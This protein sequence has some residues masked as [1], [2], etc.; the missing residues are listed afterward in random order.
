MKL[1][2]TIAPAYR[3]LYLC[4][5][6]VVF[7]VPSLVL[8]QQVDQPVA[9][10]FTRRFQI[11]PSSQGIGAGVGQPRS[12]NSEFGESLPAGQ[13]FPSSYFSNNP[14]TVGSD[15]I[16][17]QDRSE[18]V[19]LPPSN[20]G[21][22]RIPLISSIG[23][24]LQRW[25]PRL[26]LPEFVHPD[27]DDPERHI[28]LGIP[29]SGTSWLNRPYHFDW[30]VGGMFGDELINNRVDQEND[31]FFGVRLGWDFDHY[32]GTEFRVGKAELGV[33][34]R[35]GSQALR[36]S[37]NEFMDLH[38]VYYPWGDAKVRPYFALGLGF[39]RFNF[40]DDT[41]L[42][43]N[44]SL[45]HLPLSMGIKY[46]FQ[47]WMAI[48][49][50]ITDNLAFGDAGVDTMQNFSITAGTEFRFGGTRRNYYRFH[51]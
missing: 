1:F 39:A 4:A 46:Y 28:G 29:L 40:T 42:R 12:E 21:W 45:F 5:L 27:P 10:P 11:L 30:F 35:Q 34:N 8:S 14:D 22:G 23:Q 31:V 6:S 36:S 44:A 48:R 38:L 25:K 24:R 17:S 15:K 2:E 51:R 49:L 33:R 37:A 32:W 26:P 47:N 16:I 7:L 19:V 13:R 41:N 43:R 20:Q 9:P 50:D 18:M 3:S